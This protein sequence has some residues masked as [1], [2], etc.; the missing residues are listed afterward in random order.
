MTDY[1][2]HAFDY[3]VRETAGPLGVVSPSKYW[4]DLALQISQEVPTVFLAVAAV[5]SVHSI[6]RTE[7]HVTHHMLNRYPVATAKEQLVLQLYCKATAALQ[8]YIDD[9]ARRR[10]SIEPVL[11]CCVLFVVFEVFQDNGALAVSHLLHGR[12]ALE[13][14]SKSK[15]G[16]ENVDYNPLRSWSHSVTD[17]LSF[18]FDSLDNEW[19]N[20]EHS[21]SGLVGDDSVMLDCNVSH[22]PPNFA[23]TRHAKEVLDCIMAATLQF[24]EELLRSAEDRLVKA[25]NTSFGQSTQ[26]C[27]AH[28]LSHVIDGDARSEVL[29]RQ[30]ELIQSHEAWLSMLCSLKSRERA[31]TRTLM[32][33]QHFSSLFSLL[34]SLSTAEVST[35]KFSSSFS[36]ILDLIEDYLRGTR[37]AKP[38]DDL[39]REPWKSFSLE[40]GLLPALYLVCLKCR[41]SGLRYRALELLRGA[42]RREGLCWSGAIITYAESLVLL[43][44]RR[45]VE[46]SGST[47]R[48]CEELEIPEAARFLDS[49]VEGVGYHEIRVVC[50]RI[51]H[52]RHNEL[53]VVEYR[54]HGFPPLQLEPM[55]TIVIPLGAESL[56]PTLR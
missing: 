32:Q 51:Q 25:G 26:L 43:E 54:G 6:Q 13:W 2:R 10:A 56:L 44:E 9:A 24:R 31:Q 17:V 52:E 33:I 22:M 19:F 7:L 8:K 45:A 4:I 23:S 42:N 14:I 55:N 16:D 53:E 1:E 11:L 41:V 20:D 38:N 39:E 35:D 15:T 27:A 37:S 12:R 29:R 3:F 5:G 21:N 46:L 30:T 49:V 50:G 47:S 40:R 36:E 48:H 18:T 34:T 28:C